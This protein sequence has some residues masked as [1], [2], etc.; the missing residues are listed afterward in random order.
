MKA[1]GSSVITP[2]SM[3]MTV[4]ARP[5]AFVSHGIMDSSKQEEHAHFREHE[6]QMGNVLMVLR[7]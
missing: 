5:V 7:H 3:L 4:H 2:Y 1:L 6:P